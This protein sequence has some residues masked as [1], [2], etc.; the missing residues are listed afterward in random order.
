MHIL[1]S[2][3]LLQPFDWSRLPTWKRRGYVTSPLAALAPK[4]WPM[5]S[6]VSGDVV[7]GRTN[8]VHVL[9]EE[10]PAAATSPQ[11]LLGLVG[12]YSVDRG[13][14]YATRLRKNRGEVL[15]NIEK[16]AASFP[17]RQMTASPSLTQ[18]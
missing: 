6:A 15:F 2:I 16:T 11:S 9:L 12:Q 3:V 13:A 8:M 1:S 14:T 10:T 4:A 17:P 7:S 18:V 5:S